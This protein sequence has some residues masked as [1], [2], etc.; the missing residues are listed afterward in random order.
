VSNEVPLCG[1]RRGRA[2]R[3][4]KRTTQI[5]QAVV[6]QTLVLFELKVGEDW[7]VIQIA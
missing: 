2:E 6:F 5:T 1:R 4:T 7:T 3:T